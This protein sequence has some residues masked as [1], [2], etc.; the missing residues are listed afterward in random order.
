MVENR[1]SA[2]MGP[3]FWPVTIVFGILSVAGILAWYFTPLMSWIMPPVGAQPGAD[4]DTLLKFMLA[5][6][7]ALYIFVAGYIIYFM[8]AFRAKPTDAPDAI[9]VQVHDNHVLELWWTILPTLF[10]VLLSILS[11]K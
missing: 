11:V 5:S 7:T 3:G 6:G 4:V 10:V 2:G 1:A 8:I 9:G